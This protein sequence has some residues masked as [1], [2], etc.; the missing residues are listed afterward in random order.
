MPELQRPGA[1][2]YYET[3]GAGPPLLLVAGLASDSQSWLPVA[4]PLASGFRLVALDNRGVGRSRPQDAETSVDRMADDCVALLDALGIERAHVLGHSMGGF[5]A[6][7]LAASHPARVDRVVLACTAVR[8]GARNAALFADMAT[9]LERDGDPA[10]WFRAFFRW[11]FTARAFDDP[12][13]VDMALRWALEYP[14]PQA[15]AGFRRQVEAVA[16]FDGRD[17]L[18][19]IAAPALVL[20]AREDIV[21]PPEALAALAAAIPGAKLAMIE[22]AAHALHTE[23]P[24]AFVDA[25]TAFLRG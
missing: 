7:R 24:R 4:T 23:Q 25:V 10:R 2:L 21:F 19:R 17:D 11:I 12:A 8:P 15:P 22:R 5:V 16:A 20:G 14:Y 1:T 3:R 13:F 9:A 6:Q 18:A